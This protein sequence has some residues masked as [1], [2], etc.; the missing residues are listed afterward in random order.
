MPPGAGG[1]SC[2]T[3]AG[4]LGADTKVRHTRNQAEVQMV[5]EWAGEI[6][7]RARKTGCGEVKLRRV[8]TYIYV[9]NQHRFLVSLNLKQQP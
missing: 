4:V 8:F 6:G 9:L 5:F 1:W 3:L 2:V 7:T